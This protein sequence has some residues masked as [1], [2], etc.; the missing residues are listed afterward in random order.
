MGRF[1]DGWELTKQSTRVLRSNRSLVWFPLMSGAAI[2]AVTAILLGVAVAVDPGLLGDTADGGAQAGPATYVI[3]VVLAVLSTF[4]GVFFN[5]A[6]AACA[7]RSL[8]GERTS[9][10]DGLSA[11]AH[12]M[13][14]ILGWVAV[15]STVGLV[16]SALNNRDSGG[17]A[18]I[19]QSIFGAGWAIASFFVIPLI[20]LEGMGPFAAL[21][22]SVGV[23]RQRWGEGATGTVVIAV[24]NRVIAFVLIV[25]GAVIVVMLVGQGSNTALAIAFV[26]GVVTVALVAL[27]GVI[28][29]AITGVFRVAVYQFALSGSA[30]AGFD[31]RI[32]AHAVRS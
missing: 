27:V 24:I 26:V 1:S 31:G 8:R 5:V 3:I 2:I 14:P 23:V 28:A 22:R 17:G 10:S 21:K 15:T 9:V 12:R 30:P 6:L 25:I 29:S 7:D 13:G 16:L 4:I 11:A 18:R 20:A 32:L 19:A